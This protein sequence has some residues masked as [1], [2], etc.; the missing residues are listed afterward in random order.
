MCSCRILLDICIIKCCACDWSCTWAHKCSRFLVNLKPFLAV[1]NKHNSHY[2]ALF[3]GHIGKG[4]GREDFFQLVLYLCCRC[5][6]YFGEIF[7]VAFMQIKH[8]FITSVTVDKK[9]NMHR[10]FA[11]KHSRFLERI[12]FILKQSKG[13]PHFMKKVMHSLIIWPERDNEWVCH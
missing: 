2:I 13:W 9:L 4:W 8:C 3:I 12:K 7:N 10:V 6:Q 1:M 11:K 5:L